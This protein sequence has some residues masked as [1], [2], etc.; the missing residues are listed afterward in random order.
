MGKLIYIATVSL[1]GFTEDAEGNFDWS[2]P[3]DDQH[4]F[5]NDL[6]RPIGTHLYG[7]RMYETMAVWETEP[8]FA[9]E[10]EVMT[11]FAH[12]WQAAQKVVYS[13]TLEA[14]LTTKTRIER[15]FEPDSIRAMKDAADQDLAVGGPNLAAHAFKSGLI[16][17]CHLFI[18]PITLGSGKPALPTDQRIDLELLDERQFDTGILYLRHRVSA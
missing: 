5:I 10:S 4:A 7:R 1:D 16:D 8:A 2:Q 13:T 11:D 15:T 6:I 18:A 17:E 3:G 9:A 14:P 12:V